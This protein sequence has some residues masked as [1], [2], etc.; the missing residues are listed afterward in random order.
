MYSISTHLSP[1]VIED[2][3]SAESPVVIN[4]FLTRASVFKNQ[5]LLDPANLR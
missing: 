5:I 4:A 1:G 2:D 3:E